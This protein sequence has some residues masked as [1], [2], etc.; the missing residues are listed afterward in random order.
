MI[1]R[2][3]QSDI[4]PMMAMG[5]ASSKGQG[6]A[7]TNTARNRMDSPLIAQARAATTSATGV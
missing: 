3:A 2:R 7:M 1:A 6:V 5:I 4:E